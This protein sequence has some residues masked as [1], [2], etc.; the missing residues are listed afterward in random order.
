[1]EIKHH[2][3]LV[4]DNILAHLE[5]T[6]IEHEATSI[7]GAQLY[8]CLTKKL[9]EEVSEVVAAG[10]RRELIE[11]LADVVEVCY[12]MAHSVGYASYELRKVRLEKLLDKGGFNN[13]DFLLTTKL[14]K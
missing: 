11:E 12:A 2:N 13:G 6:G 10:T 3:K 4:R 9:H 5:K 8:S 1:L 14:F 7:K